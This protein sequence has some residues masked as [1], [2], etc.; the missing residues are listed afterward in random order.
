[1][2]NSFNDVRTQPQRRY[3]RVRLAAISLSMVVGIALLAAKFYAYHLTGSSAILSDALESIINVAASGF[4]LI[5]I[6]T[7]ARPPDE[8]HPYGHG[9]I[10]FFSA[11]F[12]G[13]LII[14]AAAGIFYTGI[15]R[16]FH[17][18]GLPNLGDG[19]AI[20]GAAAAINLIVGILLVRTGKRTDSLTL[21][22]D[23]KHLL[24]DVYTS[25]GVIVGLFL[26]PVT[27]WY[28]LDGVI[29]CLVGLNILVTGVGLVRTSFAGLM[30]ESD[31]ILLEKITELLSQHRKE[32]WID[33]HQLRSWKAGNHVHIDLHLVLP[34]DLDLYHAHEEAKQVELILEDHFEGNAGI[35]VHIDPCSAP[36]C[37]VCQKTR[38]E[39]R[40]AAMQQAVAWNTA[41][42]TTTR[43]GD[44]VHSG[45]KQDHREP[46]K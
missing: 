36:D 38:C 42:L 26:V 27:G 37:P 14:L 1:M 6:V 29:A 13:A 24:T 31:P 21:V 3:F 39:M 22:A 5:S 20:L 44:P 8:S 15:E 25:A 40:T 7:A 45:T 11:G 10:E 41:S 32:N 28:R 9:K 33:I 46:E 35:L 30:D 18:Q 12:E 4:A 2:P 19:I 43:S 17:P 16:V 23:G 34:R